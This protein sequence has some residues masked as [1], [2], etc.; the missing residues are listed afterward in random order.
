MGKGDK[1][2]VAYE[3]SGNANPYSTGPN[4]SHIM[5]TKQLLPGGIVRGIIGY[6][7]SYYGGL[8]Y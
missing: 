6:A 2:A 5:W 4:T 8:N 3:G 1:D 7:E